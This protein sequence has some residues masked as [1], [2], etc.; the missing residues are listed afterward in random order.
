LVSGGGGGDRRQE[1]INAQAVTDTK[2]RGKEEE[3]TS[4]PVE[5]GSNKAGNHSEI[6]RIR[7]Q[8]ST[9]TIL[10]VLTVSFCERGR[11]R[12]YV[13]YIYIYID[14]YNL[15]RPWLTA[16]AREMPIRER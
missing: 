3:R 5:R 4:V 9:C 8:A 7:T 12:I 13:I 10:Q 2:R 14:R 16:P 15:A 6:G 11:E 1:G